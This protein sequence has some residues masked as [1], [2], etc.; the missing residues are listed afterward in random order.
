MTSEDLVGAALAG[1]DKGEDITLPFVADATVWDKFDDA[2]EAVRR[3]P[4]W[5]AR[6]ALSRRLSPALFT[7]GS[8]A[9]VRERTRRTR[10]SVS[11]SG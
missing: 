2:R 3:G 1:F 4:D 7:L 6:A 8:T 9:W 10:T 5:R 11:A